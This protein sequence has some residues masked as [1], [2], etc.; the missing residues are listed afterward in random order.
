MEQRFRD[1]C[2]CAAAMMERD[3]DVFSPVAHSHSVA[4]HGNLN[5]VD[6]DFWMKRDMPFMAMCDR[7]YILEIEGWADSKGVDEEIRIF[8]KAGKPIYLCNMLG[9][10]VATRCN[11]HGVWGHCNQCVSEQTSWEYE[12]MMLH[13]KDNTT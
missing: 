1:A 6:H 9:E 8:A 13:A 7:M 10:P 12:R 3:E 2:K 5:G 4:V 11:R